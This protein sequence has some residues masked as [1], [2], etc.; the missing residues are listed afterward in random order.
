MDEVAPFLNVKTVSGVERI[1]EIFGEWTSDISTLKGRSNQVAALRKKLDGPM[2][3]KFEAEFAG[4]QAVEPTVQKVLKPETDFAEEC[5]GQLLFRGEWLQPLNHVPFLLAI[6]RFWKIYLSPASTIAMPLLAV[7]L[8]YF[9]IRFVFNMPMPVST[10]I[11]VLRKVYSG[12]LGLEAASE[13]GGPLATLK[14]YAQTGWLA[15]NFIQSMWQP[16]QAAMHLYKLDATLQGEGEA[17][18]ELV[19][20]TYTLRDMFESVGFKSAPLSVDLNAVLDVRRAVATV[21]EGEAAMRMLLR[22]LGEYEIFYRLASNPDLCIVRWIDNKKP[23]IRIRDT[24][25]IRVEAAARVPISCQFGGGKGQ[26]T[27]GRGGL[28]G[29]HAPHH[30]MLTGPNRGGKSTALRAI[31]RSVFMAHCFGVA[32]G[33]S[34]TM[35]P[36]HY[37]Q[38]CLRLED[39]PGQRSLF[40]REVAIASLALRRIRAKHR[41][42][43][44]IDE[45]F[46]STNPPDAEIASRIFLNE[47]W[48]SKTTLS[49]ISTH[50]FSLVAD[51][52]KI[53]Q[54]QCPATQDG[55]KVKYKYGLAPGICRVSSVREILRE[56][57]LKCD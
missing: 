6:L 11:A 7:I 51:T 12:S 57:G 27:N 29:Q 47:L 36:L 16:V 22:Q 50:L 4:I 3:E 53:Q 46:H 17:I 30:A 31:G 35:T 43:L 24:F 39:I 44:L 14:V 20:R 38:T 9:L 45:L 55:Y 41:G 21:L 37:M 32:I 10:Y 48:N 19:L 42:L 40:E 15:F 33:K 49:V 18:R 56:Q 2:K 52:D 23:A 13:S 26:H 34:A 1:G 25:D 8:P 54:L 28:G 5:Y